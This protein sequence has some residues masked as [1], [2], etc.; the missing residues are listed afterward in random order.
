MNLGPPLFLGH[1][2]RRALGVWALLR[3]AWL[4]VAV[5]AGFARPGAMPPAGA[6][7]IV[8]LVVAVTWIDLHSR[9]LSILLPNFGIALPV[10]VPAAA[11]VA[12]AAEVVAALATP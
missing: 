11:G 10:A 5:T 9:N 6:G 2:L 7:V 3:L 12:T 1:L 4:A 8:A